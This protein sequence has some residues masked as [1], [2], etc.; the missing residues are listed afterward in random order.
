MKV[1]KPDGSWCLQDW[2]VSCLPI[3]W[4]QERQ[5]GARPVGQVVS[6]Y[7]TVLPLSL[8]VFTC[9]FHQHFSQH[10]SRINRINLDAAPKV[11]EHE[12]R[13]CCATFCCHF[14]YYTF[15]VSFLELYYNATI[16]SLC[17]WHKVKM[18]NIIRATPNS[19]PE[20]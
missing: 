3:F 9:K 1:Q 7:S 12:K 8:H 11:C 14:W 18:T 15:L 6:I 19:R 17:Q 16:L 13:L 5:S 4:I 20:R 2:H 10:D